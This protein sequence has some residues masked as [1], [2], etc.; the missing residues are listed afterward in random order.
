[1]GMTCRSWSL[2][3][4][5]C[6]IRI[7]APSCCMSSRKKATAISQP[8][9]PETSI[10]PLPSSTWLPVSRKKAP[11]ARRATPPCSRANSHAVLLPT[12]GLPPSPPPCLLARGWMPL[13]R[14]TRTGFLMWALPSSMPSPLPPVWLRKGCARSAPSIPP[15]SSAPMI[16]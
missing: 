1:M 5:T 4:A 12:T 3:C 15:S 8:K 2:S 10:T 11:Q 13:P 7:T 9:K 6:A 16:R 14:L